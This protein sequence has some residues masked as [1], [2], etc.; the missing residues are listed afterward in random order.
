MALV[1]VEEQHSSFGNVA[2][3]DLMLA[4]FSND[5][6]FVVA[7]RDQYV[8]DQIKSLIFYC[9]HFK[10]E[11]SACQIVY[12]RFSRKIRIEVLQFVYAK[13]FVQGSENNS[14]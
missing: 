8:Q 3:L 2:M 6:F 13:L 4:T 1:S 7:A 14:E 11:Q 12:K 10:A 5:E 9:S